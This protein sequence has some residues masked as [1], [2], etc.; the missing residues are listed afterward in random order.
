MP[1]LSVIDILVDE[2]TEV[3]SC[4]RCGKAVDDSIIKQ[5]GQLGTSGWVTVSYRRIED[6]TRFANTTGRR[7]QEAL[8]ALWRHS[9][10]CSQPFVQRV[11]RRRGLAGT[12][13]QTRSSGKNQ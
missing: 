13:C 2:E 6:S 3:R 9:N 7:L 8:I 11:D 12:G 1:S 10:D 4:S 5:D